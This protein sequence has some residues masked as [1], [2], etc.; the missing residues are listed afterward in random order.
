MNRTG[1]HKSA[2]LSPRENI[3]QSQYNHNHNNNTYQQSSYTQG[4]GY[5]QGNI[6]GNI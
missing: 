4:Q 1:I 6:Q 5:T 3:T 2:P